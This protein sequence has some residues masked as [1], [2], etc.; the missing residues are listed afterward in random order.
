MGVEFFPTVEGTAAPLGPYSMG[1]KVTGTLV[2]VAGQLGTDET[3]QVVPGGAGPQA[4][5]CL[6]NVQR[7]LEAAGSSMDKVFKLSIFLTNMDDLPHIS[8]ARSE[9]WQEGPFRLPQRWRSRGWPIRTQ[10]SR[11]KPWPRYSLAV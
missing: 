3:G 10:S 6:K 7:V 11:S 2:F 4:R 5:Q 8:A 9:V 1:V